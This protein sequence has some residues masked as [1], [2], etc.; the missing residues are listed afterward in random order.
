M[1]QTRRQ[2]WLKWY[3]A[4]WRADVQLRMCSYAARGLWADL[5]TL[6]HEAE[7]YGHLI[8]GA[9]AP[10]TKQLAALLGATPKET[11]ALLRELEEAGVFSRTEAGVIYSRRMVRDREKDQ[12]DRD[13]GHRG[14]NPEILRGTVPKEARVR[15]YRRSDSPEKTRRIFERAKGTCHWCS[16]PLRW[17][18]EL[19]PDTFHVDHVIA[20]RDGGTNDESNL[21]AACA[22][23]NHAR[24]RKSDPTL[25]SERN[26]TPTQEN[27]DVKAQKLE[28]RS[29]SPELENQRS[30]LG[31]T[32][33]REGLET[34]PAVAVI[35]LFDER[36]RA[37]FGQQTRAFPASTDL[38]TAQRWLAAGATAALLRGVF[39]A[40]MTARKSKGKGPIGSL[41][42]LDE[43]VA[44]AVRRPAPLTARD[45]AGRVV[46]D[47]NR[48]AG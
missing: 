44:E 13:A 43:A 34:A 48:I 46:A 33:A 16:R 28:A 24:D 35:A 10:S 4:D 11:E 7:P 6:M 14:G 17:G 38:V 42:Y 31:A 40:R 19:G 2:P 30:D 39:D 21:V 20:V 47:L 25:M 5:L 18:G 9:V 12:A 8:V 23:C 15:P 45:A 32:A 41:S 37:H 22:T 27:S 1:T 29:Y 3:P 26:P 36:S